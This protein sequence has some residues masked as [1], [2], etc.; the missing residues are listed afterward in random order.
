MLF[1]PLRFLR[2]NRERNITLLFG[3]QKRNV[4]LLSRHCRSGTSLI[5]E[6][7]RPQSKK[8]SKIMVRK[9][10]P[11]WN[12]SGNELHDHVIEGQKDLDIVAIYKTLGL[13]DGSQF[14]GT[15]DP[16]FAI[17]RALKDYHRAE[18]PTNAPSFPGR[19]ALVREIQKRADSLLEGIENIGEDSWDDFESSITRALG[20][21][22]S[23]NGLNEKD[24]DETDGYISQEI[25]MFREFT[26]AHI[27][28][29]SRLME[30][31]VNEF[32]NSPD[33]PKKGRPQK[34]A[35]QELIRELAWIYERHNEQ[36]AY[37]GFASFKA[38]DPN[39]KYEYDSAFFRFLLEIVPKFDRDSA[40]TNNALGWQIR[41][42]LTKPT[43]NPEPMA[44]YWESR[45]EDED[46]NGV[47]ESEI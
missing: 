39:S 9:I 37:D 12:W 1:R 11:A 24:R 42:A 19:L 18:Y 26:A 15:D 22:P 35:L 38:D 31:V 20:Q 34:I 21:K 33:A 41:Q 30:I 36:D 14:V 17:S 32:P 28:E 2:A 40:S 46:L 27:C 5:N 45:D 16:I 23:W 4:T 43:P 7:F 25:S 8:A 29:F 13:G 47:V 44:I 3:L 10:A 6:H